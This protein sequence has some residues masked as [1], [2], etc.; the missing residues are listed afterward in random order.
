[1]VRQHVGP[2]LVV[3]A[4]GEYVVTV[5]AL[6]VVAP[7][8]IAARIAQPYV[9]VTVVLG[10][11]KSAYSAVLRFVGVESTQFGQSWCSVR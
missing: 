6:V 11:P 8:D 7:R 3:P 10:A 2:E 5:V 4:V 9:V 1:M